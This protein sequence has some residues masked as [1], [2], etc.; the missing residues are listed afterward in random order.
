MA[1][2]GKQNGFFV[3]FEGG[4]GSGKSTQIRRLSKWL[5]RNGLKV[6][7]SK[8]PGGTSIGKR[9]RR[10]LLD[11]K[12]SL[13]PRAELFLYEADRAQHVDEK[14]TPALEAGKI[15]ISDRFMDSTTVYQGICRQFG[16]EW[17]EEL[18]YFAT[19]GL[20]PDLVILLDLP[21]NIGFRRIQKRGELD[22]MESEKAS[23]HREVRKGFLSLVKKYPERFAVIDGTQDKDFVTEQIRKVIWR[24]LQ[25]RSK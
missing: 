14:I 11:P 7:V 12:L 18:N 23:F 22:R 19:S 5:R 16:M 15:V 1:K 21:P 24:K 25:G 2:K 10:L 9:I 17:T 8:E 3:A 20:Y 13:S 6:V 4:E